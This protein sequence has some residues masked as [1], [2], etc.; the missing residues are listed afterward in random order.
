VASFWDTAIND[1]LWLQNKVSKAKVTLKDWERLHKTNFTD[2]R[3][4]AWK[5]L[6]LNRTSF[7]GIMAPSA[8]PLGGKKQKSIYKIDCRFS[9]NSV[10]SRLKEIWNY[11]ERVED[12]AVADW[13]ETI[14]KYNNNFNEDCLI[15]LDPPF[16]H[17][18]EKLYRHYFDGEEHEKLVQKLSKLKVPWILSYDYCDEI[19]GILKK[20]RLG[21]RLIDVRYSSNSKAP[22]KQKK[23]ILA[24]NL[25]LPKRSSL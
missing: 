6:F 23:E 1:G 12:V 17:K 13:D 15:Y 10:L 8:G 22:E 7:S 14:R 4:N 24:S 11:R 21:Y 19:V 20:Y 16:F 25:N 3:A 9:R 18:A 5:C 2:V